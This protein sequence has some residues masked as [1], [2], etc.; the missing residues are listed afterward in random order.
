MGD[1]QNIKREILACGKDPVYFIKTYVKIQHPVRG[2]IP[3]T[4][5]DYQEELLRDLQQHRFNVIL[6]ARQ[7][8]ISEIVAAYALWMIL[9]RKD[10]NIIVMASKL[11]TAKNI[12]RKV[13]TAIKKL[14]S[15]L[16]LSD[17]V[18]D[19]VL[20]VE[21]TNGSRIKAITSASDAG[22]SEAVSLLIADEAAF[23]E[24]FDELWTG[25]YPTVS[26]GGRAI[27]MST[28]NG[29]GNK[30]H[31][32]YEDAANKDNE[33]HATKLMWWRHPE[34]IS[35]IE[36]DPYRP[37]FKT[38]SWFRNEI[39]SSNMSS[40][41][42]AQELE[43][44]FLS[45]GETVISAE[46]I[47]QLEASVYDPQNMS[48]DDRGLHI[49]FEPSKY[50][51]YMISA[52]VARGD[53]KDY[54]AFHVFD[55]STMSQVAEYLGRIP[56]NMYAARLCDIG[57]QYNNALLVIENNAVGAACLEHVKLSGYSNVYFSRKGDQKAGEAIN[58]SL[59]NDDPELIAGFTTSP[60]NRLL[61]ITKLEE[62]IRTEAV[63]FRSRRFVNQLRTFVW[64]NERPQ[65][66]R[67]S[68]DDLI[69][70]AAIGVWIRE[71]FI[72][73]SMSSHETSRMLLD[74]VSRTE[75]LNTD[76]G[77]ASK[78]PRHIPRGP[79]S[80]LGENDPMKL[81]MPNGH[82][83]DWSWLITVG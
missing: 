31:Q 50:T 67:G 66:G 43:C 16:V 58:T 23:I 56:P 36:D 14:P 2:L 33:F 77:G 65:G 41:E 57:K 10:K 81:R 53:G 64:V 71:T 48:F 76:I 4:T 38:S 37:G 35:D 11:E 60:K 25:L 47:A 74:G 34:R 19:S 21:L 69:M 26:A 54:S 62:Q 8:G 70:A 59:I 46:K 82:V 22:R 42:I 5:F 83:E 51:S 1:K 7:L 12:I 72:G 55:I 15:W 78:D 75:T 63:V 3:F 49:W 9:F 32:L 29:V 40:K 44:S 45:S 6:K 80:M 20:T 27:V 28:P 61:M 68:S 24:K 79:V 13:R 73:P 30:F 18:G 52:D 17:Q 39:K